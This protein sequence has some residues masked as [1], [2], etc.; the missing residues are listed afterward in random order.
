MG[1]DSSYDMLKEKKESVLKRH[2]PSDELQ[3]D[4]LR[5]EYEKLRQEAEEREAL[6][7]KVSLE[8]DVLKVTLQILKKQ[9]ASIRTD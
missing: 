8:R 5:L 1:N 7:H 6:L 4:E 2:R 3:I 9:T